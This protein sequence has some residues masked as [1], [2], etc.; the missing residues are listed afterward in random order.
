M[1]FMTAG[2]SRVRTI[3][4]SIRIVKARPRPNSLTASTSPA[5]KPRNTTIM[6][7][8]AMVTIRPLRCSPI[9]TAWSVSPVLS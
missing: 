9:A 6:R 1:S 5:V 2:T 3:V 8:A 4:A 7:A